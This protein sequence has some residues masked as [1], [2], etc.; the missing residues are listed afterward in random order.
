MAG[1]REH[2]F[3][4]RPSGKGTPLPTRVHT[5]SL[6]IR[7]HVFLKNASLK[8]ENTELFNDK[9]RQDMDNSMKIIHNLQRYDQNAQ[10]SLQQKRWFA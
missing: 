10:R 7:Y 9:I 8:I 2:T 6:T 3:L 1:L 5:Q 4:R